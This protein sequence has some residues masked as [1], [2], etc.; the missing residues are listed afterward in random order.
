MDSRAPHSSAMS[1]SWSVAELL[2]IASPCWAASRRPR[3]SAASPGRRRAAAIS[4]F[5]VAHPAEDSGWLAWPSV[6]GSM[7]WFL[8]QREAFF[9]KLQGALHVGAFWLAAVL[10]LW[11]VTR[12]DTPDGT[13]LLA[14]VLGAV[15]AGLLLSRVGRLLA[16]PFVRRT[17]LGA[18]VAGWLARRTGQV[19]RLGQLLDPLADRLY[20]FAT[21]L[22]LVA[23]DGLPLWWALALI[24]RPRRIG[25]RGVRARMPH[26]RGRRDRQ[27]P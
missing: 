8:R 12:D 17:A 2:A 23:R 1:A 10:A 15:A 27:N 5:F 26:L 21:V 13:G 6:L 25:E 7:Y 22:A 19:S 4:V 20:I 24:S 3:I 16:G 9:P 14:P 18:G 11:Q